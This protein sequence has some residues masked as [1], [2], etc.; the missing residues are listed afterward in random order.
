MVR[1]LVYREEELIGRLT[2][3]LPKEPQVP[4]SLDGFFCGLL[5][6]AYEKFGLDFTHIEL[7]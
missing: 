4:Y 2:V 7:E 1:I 3:E 5:V 6:R